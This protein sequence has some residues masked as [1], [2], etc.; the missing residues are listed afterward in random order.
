[1]SRFQYRLCTVKITLANS[2]VH[3]NNIS[4]TNQNLSI[5]M[6][7]NVFF[8]N[9]DLKFSFLPVPECRVTVTI[10][11]TLGNAYTFYRGSI[12]GRDFIAT[13]LVLLFLREVD[14]DMFFKN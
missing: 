13:L 11:V 8:D 9:V 7:L 4:P 1:M 5:S 12:E 10:T 14:S 2:A 6:G 3:N